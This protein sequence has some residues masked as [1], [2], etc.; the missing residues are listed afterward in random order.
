MI[1][2]T[3]LAKQLATHA[4]L[5]SVQA[6]K[7]IKQ[8]LENDPENGSLW[9]RL[10]DS[11]RETGDIGLATHAYQKAAKLKHNVELANY[12]VEIFQTKENSKPLRYPQD[13]FIPVPFIR[14]FDFLTQTQMQDVWSCLD[15][16][17][18]DFIASG[19]DDLV[20]LTIDRDQ[21]TSQLL[22]KGECRALHPVFKKPLQPILEQAYQLFDI[23]QPENG[24]IT[25]QMTSHADGEYYRIHCDSGPQYA[26]LLSY[27]YYFHT[28]PKCFTG[29]ELHL[30]DT[31]KANQ[32][33]CSKFTTIVPLHNS[34]VVFPSEYYHQVC[35]VNLT[36]E[37]RRDGRNTLNGWHED[38]DK[39]LAIMTKLNKAIR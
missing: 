17:R 9:F 30:Y 3:A 8:R 21:R 18:T 33:H 31:S 32:T 10:G 23:S 26:R 4:R 35:T 1:K 15:E 36:S 22:G 39:Q 12:C 7:I 2:N 14:K 34:L 13:E 24:N 37:D 29:G 25:L 20:E 16:N 19:I 38:R 28:E 11:Y 6:Q 27:V 5:L